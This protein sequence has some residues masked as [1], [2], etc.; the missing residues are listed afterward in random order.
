[1]M[2]YS[3]G[4]LFANG[5]VHSIRQPRIPNS[6]PLRVTSDTCRFQVVWTSKKSIE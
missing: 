5:E 1:M 6:L 2:E 3:G 4:F